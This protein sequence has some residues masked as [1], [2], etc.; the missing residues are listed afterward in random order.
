MKKKTKQA[1]LRNS[2]KN[3]GGKNLLQ[4]LQKSKVVFLKTHFCAVLKVRLYHIGAARVHAVR[5]SNDR[6]KMYN[7]SLFSLSLLRVCGYTLCPH[8]RVLQSKQFD[9]LS[10]QVP[11]INK[12]KKYLHIAQKFVV[13]QKAVNCEFGNNG[14]AV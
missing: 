12:K 11:T 6:L 7:Y 8:S 14:D 9:Q 13:N 10:S 4:S 5:H 2:Y 1:Q 3:T